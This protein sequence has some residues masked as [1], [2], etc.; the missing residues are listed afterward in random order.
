MILN[1]LTFCWLNIALAWLTT[2]GIFKSPESILPQ[3]PKRH[4]RIVVAPLR[5]EVSQQFYQ[6]FVDLLPI[7]EESGMTVQVLRQNIKQQQGFMGRALVALAPIATLEIAVCSALR[8][9]IAEG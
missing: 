7:V 4:I 8:E 1:Q 2:F 5:P 6:R 3:P 9:V